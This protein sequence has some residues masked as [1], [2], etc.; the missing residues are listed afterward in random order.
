MWLQVDLFFPRLILLLLF[1]T[2]PSWAA[3]KLHFV[4]K[5]ITSLS[6]K[7]HCT[8]T[9][10]ARDIDAIDED[11]SCSIRWNLVFRIGVDKFC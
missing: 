7:G 2:I 9:C 11:N 8:F 5:K 10:V 3:S 1:C 6:S 4:N